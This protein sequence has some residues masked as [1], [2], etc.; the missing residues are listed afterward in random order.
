MAHERLETGETSPFRG[1][2][3]YGVGAVAEEGTTRPIG[4]LTELPPAHP[5]VVAVG[6]VHEIRETAGEFGVDRTLDDMDLSAVLGVV[7]HM[8]AQAF[9]SGEKLIS[10]VQ[11]AG[12]D[13]ADLVVGAEEPVPD[14][15][16]GRPNVGVDAA[17]E[18][19]VVHGSGG[20]G[21]EQCAGDGRP[22]HAGCVVDR[23]VPPDMVAFPEDLFDRDEWPDAHQAGHSEEMSLS[24]DCAQ[25][26]EV[27][28]VGR[29]HI[30]HGR[31]DAP[32]VEIVEEDRSFP[33]MEWPSGNLDG[34]APSAV[35]G[36]VSR[37]ID[38]DP[39]LG[40]RAGDS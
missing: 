28:S 1:V 5:A 4:I 23:R 20:H 29:N 37:L 22:I 15:W 3:V 7:S 21:T 10:A 14:E 32:T 13:L 38:H 16:Q 8:A 27:A 39:N 36:W 33:V 34:D 26:L 24:V 2:D 19:G 11:L 25:K 9:V 35:L 12:V 30:E 17:E 6:R 31:S 40:G 18:D